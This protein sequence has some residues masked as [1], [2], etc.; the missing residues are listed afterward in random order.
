[1]ALSSPEV[2]VPT[3]EG[4]FRTSSLS[5]IISGTADS[6]TTKVGYRFVVVDSATGADPVYSGP[7]LDTAVSFALATVNNVGEPLPWSFN[8]SLVSNE[9]SVG[10]T[11]YVEFYAINEDAGETSY[12][13]EVEVIFTSVVNLPISAPVPTGISVDRNNTFLRPTCSEV[14]LDGYIGEFLGYNFYVSLEAGGGTQGY[15]LM[16]TDYVVNP[17]SVKAFDSDLGTTEQQSGDV[18][19]KT[20][21]LYHKEINQYSFDLNS[22]ALAR[23]TGSG[24]LPN[25]NYDQTT[26]FYFV[27]TTVMYDPDVGAVVES[28]FSPEISARFITFAAVYNEIPVRNRD[29]ITVTLM[30]RIYGKNKKAHQMPASVYKDLLDP[31]S[32]EY[33]DYY[34]IQDFLA[35]TESIKGLLQFD[36][37]N[38]DGVSDPVETSVKK[39]RL[40]LALKLNNA[41]AVQNIIDSFFEKK[42]SNFNISRLSP[43]YS[44][45]KALFYAYSIPEEGLLISD[46][47]LVA[48]GPGMGNA[49]APVTFRVT[50]SKRI[51][52]GERSVFYNT[53]DKRYEIEADIIST[54]FGSLA[55]V[56][57]GTISHAVSGADPRF[58]VENT[59]PTTGGTNNES[60]LSLANRTQLAIAGVDTGT[61]GGYLLKT[62]GVP[63]VR[64]ARVEK[65]GDPMMMRD[66]DPDS[67]RHLGGKVDI[68]VQSETLGEKQDIIAFSYA[69]PT[70]EGSEEQF[71][72][73]DAINFRIRTNNSNVTPA[74]PIFEVI[75]VY[76]V[77]R[78]KNYDTAG[79]VVGLGDGDT[80]QLSQNTSNLK[81][82]MATLDVIEVD[83]RYRGSNTYVMANQPVR[84]IVSVTGDVDGVLPPESYELVKLEDPLQ[85]GESTIARDGVAINFF[86]GYPTESSRTVTAEAHVFL[87]TKPLRLAKKGVDIDAIVVSSDE[88]GIDTYEKDL[89]FTIGKGGQAGYTYLY[90]Q[91]YSK[92]RSGSEVFVSYE[93]SQNL[94]VVYTVNEALQTVQDTVDKSQHATADVV[95]KGAVQNYVDI[96]LQ[97]IRRRG[98]T[99]T[100][101]T[102]KVQTTLGNY[103]SNLHVGQGLM[104]DDVISLVKNTEGVKTLVLPITRMMKQN[105]SFIP[106]DYIGFANFKVYTRNASRGVTSYVSNQPVLNYGTLDNGGPSNMFRA[107]YEGSTALVMASSPLDVSSSLGRGYILADGRILV[108][109]TDGA[110]PQNK[111]YSASYYTYVAPENEFARDIQVSN[112]ETLVVDSASIRVDASAEEA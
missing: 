47:A 1:M 80:V 59:S 58:Q 70:G 36:D 91:P 87:S 104:V 60:N 78:G 83:Y 65:G 94:K 54:T 112:I 30:Q 6:T 32:E 68:Y 56:P 100:S 24:V 39:T 18:I 95:V 64:S 77:T 43:T 2:L 71:F 108:S 34:V 84:S 35:Q 44:K 75:R 86:N 16:N 93:H 61:E 69:G 10:S 31:I 82:G 109:T 90:M 26:T 29:Q 28:P 7:I 51:P 110:P 74:T 81:I 88:D 66:I 107:I 37:E 9:V 92:I 111:E 52:Y 48:T 55:N 3:I 76:N 79:A 103:I 73:E 98:Y 46:G 11:L 97:I 85:N 106:Q 49:N 42:A 19:V 45:G 105:E 15:G 4:S 25:Q 40:R 5:Q 33:S 101:V 13:T 96:Y 27:M 12:P 50:G 21:T 67:K 20:N 14:D 99:E 72:V 23:L 8:C 38:G 53:V 57:A 17:S 63:G 102:N 22:E 89:D 41:D 62:L